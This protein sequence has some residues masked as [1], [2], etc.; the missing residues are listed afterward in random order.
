MAG[1][2]AIVKSRCSHLFFWHHKAYY[3]GPMPARIRE[4][5][6]LC[7]LP[8]SW[9]QVVQVWVWV[10]NSHLS[11]TLTHRSGWCG[12][13]WVF[14]SNLHHYHHVL[15]L[16]C[17]INLCKPA[18]K[19]RHCLPNFRLPVLVALL[20]SKFDNSRLPMMSCSKFNNSRL[21]TLS[22]SKFDSSG[23]PILSC[24]KFKCWE[25]I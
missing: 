17:K 6:R 10:G 16:P 23:L 7:N 1:I 25:S 19:F 4:N 20:C 11:E 12:L 5:H 13:V 3:T 22:C 15:W 24:F 8:R 21:P 9:V 14:S 18:S 2:R